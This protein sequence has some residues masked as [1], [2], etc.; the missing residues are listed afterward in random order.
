MGEQTEDVVRRYLEASGANDGD[1]LGRLRHPDWIEDWPQA[2][3][4]IRGHAQFRAIHD[5]FPRGMPAI[6]MQ[7]LRGAD[8]RY[9]VTPM[10]TLQ[11]ISG[12][13]DVWWSEAIWRYPNGEMYHMI[14]HLELLDG[15]IHRERTFWAAPFEAPAW[16][17]ELVEQIPDER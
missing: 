14:K 16:R 3:A 17:A 11:R 13:G 2:G 4:Q 7:R 8:D 15:R 12:S 9:V 5:R 6:E 10:Y 1:A